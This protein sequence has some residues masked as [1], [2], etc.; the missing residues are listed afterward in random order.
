MRFRLRTLL[1]VLAVAPPLLALIGISVFHLRQTPPSAGGTVIY[2]GKPVADGTIEFV[3]ESDAS[4]RFVAKTD[5]E[6]RYHLNG[7]ET[8]PRMKPGRYRVTITFPGT[9]Q[10]PTSQLVTDLQPDSKNEIHF[11]LQ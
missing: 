3:P 4:H 11:E 6:G 7:S 8:K 2:R 10:P 1:I 9:G 5:D